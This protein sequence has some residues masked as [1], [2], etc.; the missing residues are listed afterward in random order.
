MSFVLPFQIFLQN[1]KFSD[2]ISAFGKKVK[3]DLQFFSNLTEK[4]EFLVCYSYTF[5]DI[6]IRETDLRRQ[7]KITLDSFSGMVKSLKAKLWQSQM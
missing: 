6:S 5:I 4:L 7:N 2:S 3:K 1:C